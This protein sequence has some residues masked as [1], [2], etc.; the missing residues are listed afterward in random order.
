M[1]AR[2]ASSCSVAETSSIM[3][4]HA[5][6]MFFIVR[7]L[8][9]TML[10]AMPAGKG[11]LAGVPDAPVVASGDQSIELTTTKAVYIDL[12]SDARD[13][14]IADP[15]VADV[16]IKTPRR[17]YVIGIKTGDT[18]AFFLDE[19]GRRILQL[20]IR[21]EKD[22]T[23]LRKALSDLLPGAELSVRS[24]NGDIV[25]SG[26]VRSAEMAE[27]ARLIARRFVTDDAGVINM[28]SL[29]RPEQVLLQVRVTEMRRTVAKRLGISLIGRDSGFSFNSGVQ[30]SSNLF[31]DLFGAALIKGS[32]GSYSNIQLFLEA[33][34]ENG[35][36]KT[37]AEPNL[38][39]MSGETANFLAGGE[40]PVPV[41]RDTNGQITLEFKPFG[42]G[43][44]FTPVVLESGRI[45]LRVSTEVSALSDEGAFELADIRVPGLTVRRAETTVEIPSGGSLVLGGLLRNDAAN[46]IRG[47]PGL[48]DIPV[49]GTLFRS[50]DFQREE[51][52]LVVIAIPY[53]VKPTRPGNLAAPTDGFTPGGD[54]DQ[55]FLGKLYSRYPGA[56]ARM[57]VPPAGPVGFILE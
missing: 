33:L 29:T 3:A 46:N 15:E 36:I 53:I 10:L 5:S 54:L 56:A 51:T 19:A 9:V 35:Y 22:L 43:L 20:D 41:G 4:Y 34:E 25:L 8:A 7:I 44:K 40:F 31:S 50:T 55:Y 57:A 37:L 45:S 14:L 6:A 17:A 23:A 27:N 2:K 16:V 38:T 49:L 13:V 52:E 11:G 48:A 32:I 18:N 21:V 26:E 28:I 1:M 12:P 42:V 30:G 39:A 24:V 47:L